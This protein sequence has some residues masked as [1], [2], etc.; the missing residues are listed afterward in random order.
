MKTY[1]KNRINNNSLTYPQFIDLT[2]KEIENTNIDSLDDA[3]KTLFEYKKLN[4]QRSSRIEKYYSVNDELRTLVKNMKQLQ[5]WIVITENWC[6]DS[7]QNLPYI[8]ALAELNSF[9]NL[10]II[11]RDSNPEVIDQYLTNG[12]RS[13]PKLI[14]F[15]EEWNELFQ[16]GPRPHAAVDLMDK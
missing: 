8:A 10:K 9:I 7:A 6:G 15:D 1:I 5:T 14:A 12:T 11:L 13:I 3:E 16:W 2:R 4:L